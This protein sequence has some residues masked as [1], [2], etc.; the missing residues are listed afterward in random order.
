MQDLFIYLPLKWELWK[1]K[2]EWLRE[3]VYAQAADI[4]RELCGD[5]SG[6]LE[7]SVEVRSLFAQ[8]V[9]YV[10]LSPFKHQNLENSEKT[11][12]GSLMS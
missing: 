9:E 1:K 5:Q 4:R 8:Q 3:K 6:V 2:R 11:G 10:D 7:L 12:L